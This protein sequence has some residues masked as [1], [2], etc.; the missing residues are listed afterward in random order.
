MFIFTP[1]TLIKSS[2]VNANFAE[3]SAFTGAWS[4]FTPTWTNLTIGNGTQV[5]Q[6]VKI[7]KTVHFTLTTTFGTTTAMGTT[8]KVSMPVALSS[9]ISNIAPIGS[10]IYY[11]AGVATWQG[12]IRKDSS[13]T[14]VLSCFATGGTYGTE[15]YPTPTLPGTFAT[16]SVIAITGTYQAS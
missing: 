13:T 16:G 11:I 12:T 4:N 10:I 5:C 2:E 1:N 14:V 15:A 6:Y 7:G 8:P 3:L 9:T